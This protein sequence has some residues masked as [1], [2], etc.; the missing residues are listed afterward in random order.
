M[1]TAA[2]TTP[3]ISTI[4]SS[5]TLNFYV[6]NVHL[7]ICMIWLDTVFSVVIFTSRSTLN[8]FTAKRYDDNFK[9]SWLT[10]HTAVPGNEERIGAAIWSINDETNQA[11]TKTNLKS[12]TR[13]SWDVQ[14]CVHSI[15]ASLSHGK[16][17]ETASE[18]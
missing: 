1:T 6:P 3:F 16:P 17:P 13:E 5:T 2:T 7:N 9:L 18:G 14:Q 11:L 15:Q 8:S 4:T 12:G 10:D